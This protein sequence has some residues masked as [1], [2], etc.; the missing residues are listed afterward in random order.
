MLLLNRRSVLAS[1][2]AG[3]AAASIGRPLA[4]APQEFDVFTASPMGAFVDSVVVLG[5][6]TGLVID[7]QLTQADAVGLAD[8]VE[9]SGRRLETVF[10]THIHPDHLMGI[11]VLSQR[12]PDANFVAHS[13]VAEILGQMGE[14]MFDEL[15]GNLGFAPGD[16]WTLPSPIEGAL[17]LEDARFEVLDPIRGD[18]GVITPVILPEF[19]AVVASDV[20][21]NGTDVWLAET[22]TEED[23]AGWRASLDLLEAC[24][25]AVIIPGHR[26]EG[27]SD[28]R[29][30]IA[31]TREKLGQW[32]EAL[33]VSTDRASLAKAVQS[34]MGTDP[35]SFFAQNAISAAYPE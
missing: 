9:A 4:A 11:A 21:Y 29:S 22:L 26:A 31:H 10:I 27:T 6:E 5:D 2:A 24:P 17:T 32:E 13:A 12:F 14:G 25:E 16:T 20:V 34:I 8:Q 1:L 30:G 23:F 28:D 35:S 19:D 7:A 33:A 18:T 3:S 15:K